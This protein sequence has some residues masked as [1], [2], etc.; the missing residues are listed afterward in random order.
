MF[1]T[2]LDLTNYI[3]FCGII[4]PR[5]GVGVAFDI[6]CGTTIALFYRYFESIFRQAFVPKEMS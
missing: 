4:T 1:Y 2:Q 5:C 6:R 3:R